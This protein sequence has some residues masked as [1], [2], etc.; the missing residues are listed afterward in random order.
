[1]H[2]THDDALC[3]CSPDAPTRHKQ[4]FGGIGDQTQIVVDG[5]GLAALNECITDGGIILPPLE[6]KP[7]VIGVATRF[8]E[9]ALAY[10]GRNVTSSPKS[11]ADETRL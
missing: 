10:A 1:M 4:C 8:V 2:P 11:P 3:H 5:P 7:N 9:I 6:G